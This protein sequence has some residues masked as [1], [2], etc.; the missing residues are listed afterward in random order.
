MTDITKKVDRSIPVLQRTQNFTNA[1]SNTPGDV[2]M[3]HDSLGY[4]ASHVTIE[5]SN[6]PMQ[7]RFNVYQTIYPRRPYDQLLRDDLPNISSGILLNT[8]SGTNSLTDSSKALV[9]VE[10]GTTYTLSKELAVA[11]IMIVTVSGNYDI[12]VS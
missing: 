5:C 6:G 1:D 4:P 2:L 7:V 3:V 11:D 10:A 9:T 12:F 8:S